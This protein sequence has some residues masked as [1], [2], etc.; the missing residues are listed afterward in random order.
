MVVH[1]SPCMAEETPSSLLSNASWGS[2]TSF[3]VIPPLP[4]TVPWL[5][6]RRGFPNS[7]LAV[8]DHA[9]A[10]TLIAQRGRSASSSRRLVPAVTKLIRWTERLV[11]E[12]QTGT[13]LQTIEQLQ[14][15]MD[16]DL[17]LEDTIAPLTTSNSLEPVRSTLVSLF[18]PTTRQTHL[19]L[20][21]LDRTLPS[22]PAM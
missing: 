7:I 9:H 15:L 20:T 2:S 3:C 8:E 16:R 21:R 19:R 12:R 5:Y 11:R 10:H 6:P 17:I 22:P 4:T 1:R 18:P 13:A 14:D